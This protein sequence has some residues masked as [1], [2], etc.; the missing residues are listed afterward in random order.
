VT[1]QSKK[2]AMN[3]F[4][5]SPSLFSIHPT[6]LYLPSDQTDIIHVK[7]KSDSLFD[8]DYHKSLLVCSSSG[9]TISEIPISGKTITIFGKIYPTNL[10]L[11]QIS[12]DEPVHQFIQIENLKS[13]EISFS[14]LFPSNLQIQSIEVFPDAAQIKPN[15]IF[16]LKLNFIPGN[17]GSFH[18]QIGFILNDVQEEIIDIT[19]DSCPPRLDLS[20]PLHPDDPIYYYYYMM[21]QIVILLFQLRRLKWR[22]IF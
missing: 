13:Q 2:P 14:V 1:N 17:V 16:N 18:S 7:F 22:K 3:E 11:N 6:C 8:V 21:I 19:F 10:S 4:S 12:F 5:I 9:R 20:L 15:S